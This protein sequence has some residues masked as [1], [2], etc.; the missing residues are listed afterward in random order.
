MSNLGEMMSA[1]LAEAKQKTDAFIL[2]KRLGW[3]RSQVQYI[4]AVLRD[5]YLS[6]ID[7]VAELANGGSK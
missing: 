6:S 7:E 3:L 1:S 4:P 2:R 5:R